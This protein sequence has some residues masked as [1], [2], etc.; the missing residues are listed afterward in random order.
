MRDMAN[1]YGQ[2]PLATRAREVMTRGMTRSTLYVAP[3]PPYAVSGEGCVVTDQFGHE[4]IDLSNNYTALLHGHAF[5]PVVAA[6]TKQLS[7]GTAFG[8]PTETEVVLAETLA[9]RTG[10]P[11]WRFN[12]SGTEAVMTAVRGARAFTGREVIVRFAGSYHGAHETVVDAAA[13][14]V[15]ANTRDISIALPQGDRAAFDEFMA[16]RG[17]E[18]AAVLVDLL[19]NRTGLV[20][21]E[22]DFV[23]HIRDTASRCG[24]LLVADEV[25][26]FRLAVG[27][28]CTVFGIE[29]DLMTVGKIIGGGFPVG[30]VGGRDDVM[31]AFDPTRSDTVSIGGTFSANPVSMVAGQVALEHF[32]ADAVEG[33]NSLGDGFRARIAEAGIR[34]NG[35]GSLARLQVDAD[36]QALWWRMY[37]LGLLTG[38]STL[39]ALSS[40]MS[41]GD[42]DEAARI[43]IQAVHDVTS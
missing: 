29:P 4:V 33:L 26:S 43:V 35:Y 31:S 19:P 39:M 21:L 15:P 40:P 11:K 2:H 1:Q 30:G 42:V 22:S 27:G 3:H 14:G 25:I 13:A 20:P 24:A 5:A 36:P 32:A 9:T 18:V 16:A 41:Q 28:M 34:V 12:N 23:R 6:V 10:L 8:L 38:T 17:N 7:L 37:E